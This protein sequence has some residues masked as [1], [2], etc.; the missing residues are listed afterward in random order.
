METFW[1][2]AIAFMLAAYV[3]LDGFDLGAGALHLWLGRSE[4][5]RR[6]ILRSIGP[7]WDGNEVWLVA[8]AG[9]MYCAFP[10]LYAAAFSGFYLPLMIVLWLLM[11]RGLGIELRHQFEGPLWRQFWDVVFSVASGLL[12]LFFG[13][14]LGNAVRGVP[15]DASG[16]FFEP[17][18]GDFVPRGRTGIL[19]WYTALVGLH[20]FAALALHGALWVAMKTTGEPA[21]RASK[22][23]SFL[24]WPTAVLTAATTV[25]T[26][27]VQPH[28]AA[29]MSS[30]PAGYIFVAM[31]V[32]GLIAA[33]WLHHRGR[34]REAFFAS[35]AFLAGMIWSCAYALYPFVLPSSIAPSL[36]LTVTNAAANRQGLVTAMAWWIPGMALAVTYGAIMYRRGRPE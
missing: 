19:D 10:A 3:V 7:V 23:A 29:R 28:V 36:G 15:L 9:A 31:A 12:A 1:F 24:W 5:E 4:G 25:A 33:K 34:V 6:D 27:G 17:L 2:A 21:A 20:A 35:A 22:A 18:W 30:A 11:G 8:T 32:G 16:T 26:W 13:A 14:A